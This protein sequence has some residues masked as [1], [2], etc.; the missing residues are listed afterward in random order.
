[1][2][3]NEATPEQ[4][5]DA[6]KALQAQAADLTLGAVRKI[7]APQDLYITN[8]AFYSHLYQR[9]LYDWKET[10]TQEELL[11]ERS[12]QERIGELEKSLSL[13]QATLEST[14][15]GILMTSRDGVIV[16]YNQKFV[17]MFRFP[18]EI[19]ASRSEP[20]ALKYIL[21]QLSDPEEVYKSVSQ[22]HSRP[23]TKGEMQDMT[24]KDGR[25]F[26]RYSQPHLIG[27]Q[28][29]G[30]VYSFRDVTERRKKDQ[31]L[32]LR[33]RAIQASTHGV[34]IIENKPNYPII[35]VN[36][37]F[38][39]I[40]G[41]SSE[42]AINKNCFFWCGTQKEEPA[43]QHM[44]LALKEKRSYQVIISNYDKN[45]TLFWGEVNIAPVPDTKGE[46]THFVAIVNDV[47]ERKKMEER[48]EHQ[49][50]HDSL[51]S[52]P[53]RSLLR[54]RLEQAILHAKYSGALV[55]IWFI[56]LDRFKIAN[57]SLGHAMGDKLLQVVA[58]RLFEC[59]KDTDTIARIGG[60]EFVIIALLQKSES[61]AIPLAQKILTKIAEPI[62]IDHKTL[63][64]TASI[65]I[66][67]YP[68]NAIDSET[69]M[70]YADM[71]M[72]RAKD[73]GRDN[74]QFFTTEMNEQIS[75]RLEFENDLHTAI[76]GNQLFLQ[77]Q[78]I[79]DLKTGEIC[80]LEALLRWQ[81]PTKGII[82]PLD[83]I[84]IAEESGLIVPIG[85]WVLAE[86][87]FQLHTM[88]KNKRKII[89]IAV[90]ISAHQF[91]KGDLI[92]VID[93]FLKKSKIPPEYLALELTE[94]ILLENTDR[95]IHILNELKNRKLSLVIDD[96]GTGYSS[97]S[98]LKRFHIDKIK[99]D[100]SFVNGLPNDPNDIA[101]IQ[102]IISMGHIMG[103]K[104]VAEGVETKEQLDLLKNHQCDEIQGF[105]YCRPTDMDTIIQMIDQPKTIL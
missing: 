57:D 9:H 38:Q 33:E 86:V 73:L 105:Y 93:K 52:L 100:K 103:L 80:S 5:E 59:I 34:I 75:K 85:E 51:T 39:K 30:R 84:P 79:V 83:F 2:P 61:E 91:K 90:N 77:Y 82:P 29:V 72:Y 69:L 36:P 48:L 92:A 74:F 27:N 3:K 18:P 35:F 45:K 78:P 15:D 97:L 76:Q 89:P 26:E 25:V 10:E 104:I 19:L 21:D 81:H 55:S 1:M 11:A 28:I 22:R 31:E 44:L 20:T 101:I 40:T 13:V 12:T 56:D 102:T 70:K 41:Y 43:L 53:N 94:S 23:D 50:T 58:Q 98:Y 49:A 47:T 46:V 67:T 8:T 64:V 95:I 88:K 99:I 87:L 4:L 62:H 42:E 65:G 54:D 63:N 60:D 16:N 37:A 32:R 6:I 71:A 17:D 96:F 7:L 68:K 24:F 14:A 66:S